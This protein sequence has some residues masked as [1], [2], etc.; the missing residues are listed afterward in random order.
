MCDSVVLSYAAINSH[1]LLA[2]RFDGQPPGAHYSDRS[3]AW[4]GT[5]DPH[6]ICCMGPLSSRAAHTSEIYQIRL[7]GLAG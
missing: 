3:Y 7:T 5:G 6:V 4:G 1:T 2:A